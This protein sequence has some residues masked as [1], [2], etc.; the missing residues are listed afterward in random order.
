MGRVA[1]PG[2]SQLGYPV[3]TAVGPENSYASL[4]KF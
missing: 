4:S 1:V 2:W 3:E